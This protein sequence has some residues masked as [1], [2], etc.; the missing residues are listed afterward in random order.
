MEILW[1]VSSPVREFQYTVWYASLIGL[2]FS[3]CL[4]IYCTQYSV[5]PYFCVL[6]TVAF[7]CMLKF[8]V[9]HLAKKKK[10]KERE[11]REN[12]EKNKRTH[13]H[14]HKIATARTTHL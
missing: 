2:K 8:M 11:P 9:V 14:T 13:T 4:P 6:T 10:K 5:I 3:H 12:A 7:F 1:L